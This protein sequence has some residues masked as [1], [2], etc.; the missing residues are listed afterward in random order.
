MS[1]EI[2]SWIVFIGQNYRENYQLY[3]SLFSLFLVGMGIARWFGTRKGLEQAKSWRRKAGLPV[4]SLLSTKQAWTYWGL[5][6]GGV[7][8]FLLMVN[9]L[10]S[11]PLTI[12][13]NLLEGQSY[14]ITKIR[15]VM[16]APIA[17]VFFLNFALFGSARRR[18]WTGLY[19]FRM[20]SI[21]AAFVIIFVI[22]GASLV[23]VSAVIYFVTSSR[24]VASVVVVAVEI[25]I[26]I[27]L[28]ASLSY[29]IGMNEGRVAANP[30]V[31]YP[32]VTLDVHQGKNL[33]EAWLYEKTD[34]DYR[35][36][37]KTGSNHIIPATNVKEIKGPIEAPEVLLPRV[38]ALINARLQRR[39]KPFHHGRTGCQVS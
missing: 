23:A 7:I 25:V 5:F 8:G 11:L 24:V 10:S 29:I 15:F 38:R 12:L 37:T 9:M 18:R 35:L 21:I 22:V 16:W 36:V 27:M 26:T 30:A 6:Q 39:R 34:S 2:N 20:V 3:A 31:N 4:A 19:P 13:S 33:D 28:S 1:P 17:N 14:D 32:L